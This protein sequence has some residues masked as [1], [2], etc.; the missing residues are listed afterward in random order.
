MVFKTL[1]PFGGTGV[2]ELAAFSPTPTC[3]AT[4]ER[5]V[6]VCVSDSPA[7]RQHNAIMS[8]LENIKRVSPHQSNRQTGVFIFPRVLNDQNN[9]KS[10]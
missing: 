4:Y 5:S 9:W 3:L 8:E 2:I 10:P 7:Y 1:F 6:N